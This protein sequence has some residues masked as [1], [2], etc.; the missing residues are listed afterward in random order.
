MADESMEEI[1][2]K[3]EVFSCASQGNYILS[4]LNERRDIDYDTEIIAGNETFKV[5]KVVLLA[6]SAY[7]EAMFNSGMQE[8]QNQK[9]TLPEIKSDIMTILIDFMYTSKVSINHEIVFE[10][11]DAAELLQMT[12]VVNCCTT[13]LSKTLSVENCFSVFG[14]AR[15]YYNDELIQKII[16]F[17]SMNIEIISESQVFLLLEIED[18]KF[19]ITSDRMVYATEEDIFYTVMK[20]VKFD[21]EN[22]NKFIYDILDWIELPRISRPFLIKI[23]AKMPIIR[24]NK[25][26]FEKII[27]YYE[28]L[29]LPNDAEMKSKLNDKK[30]TVPSPGDLFSTEDEV[31]TNCDF[32]KDFGEKTTIFGFTLKLSPETIS[33][34]SRCARMSRQTF[35]WKIQVEYWN[36]E[37]GRWDILLQSG[38]PTSVVPPKHSNCLKLNKPLR[39]SKIKI[40]ILE[41]SENIFMVNFLIPKLFKDIDFGIE[42]SVVKT[43]NNLDLD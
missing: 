26:A 9:L 8:A 33:R 32:T 21:L 28:S 12:K 29:L 31:I 40:K 3:F 23:I 41:H 4:K 19:I 17:M 34:M 7:F 10:L 42:C 22:R 20:W 38:F 30:R 18:L 25:D 39:T 43:E 37:L 5:H 1:E 13:F 14:V 36:N 15:L 35:L 6:Q 11:L 27:S 2:E 16:I 24:Q